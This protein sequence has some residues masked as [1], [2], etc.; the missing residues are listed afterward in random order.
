MNINADKNRLLQAK[1]ITKMK[2]D[3]KSNDWISV[4]RIDELEQ[5]KHYFYCALVPSSQIED[6]LA[7]S[8][9]DLEFTRGIPGSMTFREQGELHRE[10]LR[11][12]VELIASNI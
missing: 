3:Y 11:F 2:R 4:Y 1:N 5:S 8:T 7:N 6:A 9:W 12:G 10:Y